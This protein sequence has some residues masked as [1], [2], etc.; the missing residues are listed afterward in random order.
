MQA[1]DIEHVWHSWAAAA[2][3]TSK[4]SVAERTLIAFL[5]VLAPGGCSTWWGFF[6]TAAADSR[7]WIRHSA[8]RVSIQC[9]HETDVRH[10][11]WAVE[12]EAA[13]PAP[14]I[15]AERNAGTDLDRSG[16]NV[17]PIDVP[18]FLWF[19]A[20]KVHAGAAGRGRDECWKSAFQLFYVRSWSHS[21]RLRLRRHNLF[22]SGG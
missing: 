15:F 10:Y 1:S 6:A 19:N 21:P 12:F 7:E 20:T 3:E 5:P 17:V 13:V 14:R 2:L 18:G 22:E 4:I 8:H 11:R 16:V 9:A